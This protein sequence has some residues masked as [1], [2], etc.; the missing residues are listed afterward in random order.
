M[1]NP[2]PLKPSNA[3][4]IVI[5]SYHPNLAIHYHS[6]PNNH[7]RF[8][9]HEFEIKFGEYFDID[10][11]FEIGSRFALASPSVQISDRFDL[12]LTLVSR[13]SIMTL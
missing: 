9:D 5:S 10:L 7:H 4:A 6:R 11:G 2:Q 13:T 1:T 3:Q 8:V 12:G